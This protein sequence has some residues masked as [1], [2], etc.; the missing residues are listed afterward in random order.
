MRL[1]KE[2]T[3]SIRRWM[4]VVTI[5]ILEFQRSSSGGV[6]ILVRS[7]SVNAKRD[8]PMTSSL[9]AAERTAA[10]ASQASAVNSDAAADTS[11]T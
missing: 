9:A 2:L 1:K 3:P 7:G 10:W 11:G 5:C 8:L 4:Y 6:P